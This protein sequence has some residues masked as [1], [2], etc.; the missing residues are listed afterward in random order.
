[1]VRFGGNEF[2]S[3]AVPRVRWALL[4]GR[5]GDTPARL[6]SDRARGSRAPRCALASRACGTTTVTQTQPPAAPPAATQ[7]P[8]QTVTQVVKTVTQ[9]APAPASSPSSSGGSSG[10]GGPTVP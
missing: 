6:G 3:F 7:A 9:A 5:A 1:M 4:R 8:V 2:T 10:G